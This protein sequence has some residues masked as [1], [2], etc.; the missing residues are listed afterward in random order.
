MIRD[1]SM[2]NKYGFWKI[3]E[4]IGSN[5]NWTVERFES[6]RSCMKAEGPKGLKVNGPKIQKWTV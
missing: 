1:V 2:T 3:S 5:Q 4:I 6:G